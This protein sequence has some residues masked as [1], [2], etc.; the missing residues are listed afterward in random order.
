MVAGTVEVSKGEGC[1]ARELP[2]LLFVVPVCVG[3]GEPFLRTVHDSTRE[4]EIRIS[5]PEEQGSVSGDVDILE[6]CH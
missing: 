6:G 1:T 4:R 3:V 5:A 2:R